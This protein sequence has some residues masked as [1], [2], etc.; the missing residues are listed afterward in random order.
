MHRLFI[1][2]FASILLFSS[3][4]ETISDVYGDKPANLTVTR[5]SVLFKV[6]GDIKTIGIAGPA[7]DWNVND[8]N[9]DKTWCELQIA[10]KQSSGD[11]IS[12]I[13]QANTGTKSRS[14]YFDVIMGKESKRVY[15][16]QIGSDYAILTDKNEVVVSNKNML[17]HLAIVSNIKFSREFDFKGEAPW[18]TIQND[19]VSDEAPMKFNIM[20]NTTG[21]DREADLIFTQE[22]GSYSKTIKFTQKGGDAEYV[23]EDMSKLQGNKKLVITSASGSEAVSGR[24][25]DKSYDNN[26]RTYYNSKVLPMKPT[27]TPVE[28]IYNFTDE[29]A[30]NYILYT[31][32]SGDLNIKGF[33]T[34][35]VYVKCRDDAEFVLD[36]T[37]NFAYIATP[38]TVI[39][40]KEY[41]NP[42]S[43]KL[44]VKSVCDTA[45]KDWFS[46]TCAEIEFWSVS[47]QFTDIFTD[48]TYS[49]L[50]SGVTIDQIFAMKDP[51]YLN[52]AQNLF[53]GTYPAQRIADYAPFYNMPQRNMN[54]LSSLHGI[55]GISVEKGRE[56]IIFAD[57]IGATPVSISIFDPSKTYFDPAYDFLIYD[58]TNKITSPVTGLLYVKYITPYSTLPTI[59]V[60]IAGGENNGYYD[61]LKHSDAEG[62]EMVSKTSNSYFELLGKRSHIVLLSE[63]VKTK[64]P[65]MS[66]LVEKYDEIVESLEE[67]IGLKGGITQRVSFMFGTRENYAYK[68]IV[69]LPVASTEKFTKIENLKGDTLIELIN[70]ISCVYQHLPFYNLPEFKRGS[71]FLYNQYVQRKLGMTTFFESENLYDEWFSVLFLEAKYAFGDVKDDPRK[72][73]PFWQLH[74]Y[75][76][77]ILGRPD[78]YQKVHATFRSRNTAANETA[79]IGVLSNEAKID[80]TSFFREH[81]FKTL[82]SAYPTKAP[83]MLHMLTETNLDIFKKEPLEPAKT[84]TYT[85]TKETGASFA[86]ATVS[87]TQNCVAYEVR[88]KKNTYSISVNSTFKIENY[89]DNMQIYGIGANGDEVLLTKK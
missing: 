24:E 89:Y 73:I 76:S 35:D 15:I 37:F 61:L 83:A 26:V 75:M 70:E 42:V 9:C 68:N 65:N 13:T 67:F 55:T 25:L 86:T 36:Q 33:R 16:V 17:I 52:I 54:E 74:L 29:T 19:Y 82:G 20:E 56:V 41:T 14:T 63:Y 50:K 34:T 5:D 45:E 58:G 59:T 47:T 80:L 51:F 72:S 69:Q 40:T 60:H 12:I 87:D 3:C 43:V 30:L 88:S 21:A 27:I 18:I 31:A 2:L 8:E 7:N 28:L 4:E 32:P 48:N 39:L 11:F 79:I 10:K 64:L 77:E 53:Y 22:G 1:I 84:G 71:L 85:I 81:G 62:M 78:F 46:V 57:N 49:K 23:P 44:V 6:E 38:Q 66:T